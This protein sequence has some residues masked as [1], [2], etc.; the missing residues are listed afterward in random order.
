M[1]QQLKKADGC[2][3]DFGDDTLKKHG[4]VNR[5]IDQCP[6]CQGYGLVEGIE[7][8]TASRQSRAVIQAATG[9]TDQ[10]AKAY[11][12]EFYISAFDGLIENL[13]HRLTSPLLQTMF[14]IE[15]I[16]VD[17]ITMP[18]RDFSIELMEMNV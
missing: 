15:T 12:K 11:W 6:Q 4:D 8:A 10:T 18:G 16:V 2:F 17:L 14:E 9:D 3:D 7:E 1:I 5:L 13:E